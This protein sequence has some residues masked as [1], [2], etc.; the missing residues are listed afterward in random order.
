MIL[1]M[2]IVIY[3]FRHIAHNLHITLL[4]SKPNELL[5]AYSNVLVLKRASPYKSNYI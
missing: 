2:V 5:W 3:G 4:Q 1:F